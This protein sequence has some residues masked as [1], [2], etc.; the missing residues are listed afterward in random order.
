[1]GNNQA[2][3]LPRSFYLL[4]VLFCLSIVLGTW[5][6]HR[7]EGLQWTTALYKA[8]QLFGAESG[9][10]HLKETPLML[11]I[12]RWTAIAATLGAFFAVVTSAFHAA[13]IWFRLKFVRGHDIVC[14]ASEKGKALAMDL[15]GRNASVALVEINANHSE[16]E[17]LRRKGAMIIVGDARQ[18]EI[19]EKAGIEHCGR[20]VCAAG[21]D[22]TNLSIAM[23]AAKFASKKRKD[24][25]DVR[26]HLADVASRDILQRNNALG[27]CDEGQFEIKAFNFFRNRARQ[28]LRDI[29]LECDNEGQLSDDVHIVLPGLQAFEAAVAVQ[30]AL[31]GHYRNGGKCT[32]H[33][34]SQDS[35]GAVSQLLKRYPR[36]EK[37]CRLSTSQSN[38]P[39]DFIARAAAIMAALPPASFCSVFLCSGEDGAILTEALMLK[40]LLPH[41]DRFRVILSSSEGSYVRDLVNRQ[42]TAGPP[43]SRWISFAAASSKACGEDAVF[44]DSLDRTAEKIHAIWYKSNVEAARLAEA[45]GDFATAVAIRDKATFKP[46]ANLTESQKD[47]NRFAADHIPVKL[48]AAG[49]DPG[50]SSRLTEDWDRIDQQTL[51]MLSR[52]EHERWCAAMWMGGWVW[53]K[54]RHNGRRE[55]PDLVPYDDLTEPSKLY[56][57]AQVR[58]ISSH[59]G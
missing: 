14:G 5:G 59:L 41:N 3:R 26:I 4:G 31:I 53:G 17:P 57:L 40:D 55:H 10:V 1:M 22:S 35:L 8:V 30:A 16:L 50:D 7:Y 42:S 48:R 36:F 28:T 56:D 32:I 18:S 47:Q 54:E 51:E 43:L 20:I 45:D 34:A 2:V 27:S 15:L 38:H 44:G 25:L 37:C 9:V 33:V 58:A 39:G 6:F 49:F 21:E 52:M 23:A 11:E 13:Q 12:A 29:P 19:L 46:W 24:C